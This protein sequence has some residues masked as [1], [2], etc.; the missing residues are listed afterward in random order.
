MKAIVQDKY[1]SADVLEFEDIDEPVVGSGDVLVRV[2]AA[3]AFIGDWH[4]MT[5]FRIWAAWPLG[6]A[7]PRP[8]FEARTSP[9][10]SRW[11]ART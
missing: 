7:G 3:S 11:S 2:H 8:A 5:A 4:I 1:G 6:S 10:V 9:A